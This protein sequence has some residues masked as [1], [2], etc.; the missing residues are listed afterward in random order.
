M[1]L[2]TTLIAGAQTTEVVQVGEAALHDPPLATQARAV[3]DAP[4]GNQRLDA[5]SPQKTTVLVVVVT[6]VGQQ[7]I[8]LAAGPTTLAP[9]GAHVQRVQERHKLGDVVA[10]AAGEC[11]R[12]GDARGVDQ[13]VV[14]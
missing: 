6:A 1:D 12:Q 11:D 14:L 10:V 3:R 8:G 4:A 5:A 13:Q 7:A 2:G 9:D